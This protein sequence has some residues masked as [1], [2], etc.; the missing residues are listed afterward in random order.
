MVRDFADF[1]RPAPVQ[2]PE[3]V[4][5]DG[6]LEEVLGLYGDLEPILERR[7]AAGLPLLKGHPTQ[8][9]QVLHNLLANAKDALEGRPDP[10]LCIDLRRVDAGVEL[11]VT[12]NGCGFPEGLITRAFEPYT[13]TKERG[14]GLGLA[15]VRKLVESH[16][17][18]VS[19]GNVEPHGALVRVF[20]PA[21]VPA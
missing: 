13:T 19:L 21:E 9:R 12:D 17:G 7:I 4:R 2:A 1:S 14:T 8:L 5:F 20:L 3:P 16:G 11:T 15:I 6:L 18:R 10:R